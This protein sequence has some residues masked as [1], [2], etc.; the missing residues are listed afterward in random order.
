[1]DI[2]FI[3]IPGAQV[4]DGE[5]EE[6]HEDKCSQIPGLHYDPLVKEIQ[7]QLPGARVWTGGLNSDCGD[8]GQGNQCR[9][10]GVE[11]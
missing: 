2:G 7:R 8:Q 10:P 9:T 6:H 4:S 5:L 11:F 1:M 3:M